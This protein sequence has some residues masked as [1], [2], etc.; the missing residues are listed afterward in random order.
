MS[1]LWSVLRLVLGFVLRIFSEEW[2]R[3]TLSTFIN[4]DV[5]DDIILTDEVI[6]IILNVHERDESID[7]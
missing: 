6:L 1:C 3:S 2:D 7:K 4:H 5:N